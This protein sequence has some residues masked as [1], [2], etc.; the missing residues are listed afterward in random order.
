MTE[1]PIPAARLAEICAA[2]AAGQIWSADVVD[3]LLGEIGRL[4]AE[5][6]DEIEWGIGCP[7]D[8]GTWYQDGFTQLGAHHHAKLR[9]DGHFPAWRRLGNWH[10]ANEETP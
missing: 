5:L 2:N 4:T 3:E 1:T 10:N 6:S 7:E 8:N 9:A